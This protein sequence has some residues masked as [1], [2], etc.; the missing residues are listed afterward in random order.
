[1]SND[2]NC[3]FG[4]SRTPEAAAAADAE[5]LGTLTFAAGQTVVRGWTF[6]VGNQWYLTTEAMHEDALLAALKHIA[7]NSRLDLVL[8]QCAVEPAPTPAASLDAER[9]ALDAIAIARW[10]DQ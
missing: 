10:R 8:D 4:S 6:D 1:M 5:Q 2:P 9:A 3:P 7:A